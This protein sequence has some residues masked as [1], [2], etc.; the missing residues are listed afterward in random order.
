MSVVEQT[1]PVF[2]LQPPR[3]QVSA[4][5]YQLV[6]DSKSLDV[7]SEYLYLLL[8]TH[9]RDTCVTAF[10]K[11]TAV[12]A[13]TGYIRPDQKETLFIWQIAVDAAARQKGLGKKMIRHL[14][15]RRSCADVRFIEA[16][17]SPSNQASLNLFASLARDLKTGL[18]QT[19]CFEKELFRD[20]DHESEDLIRIGPFKKGND[21]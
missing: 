4:A 17:V 6:V 7:N 11:D 10:F 21:L 18:K 12:G 15:E 13:A 1:D 2:T 20:R 16:T 5:V 19:P 8:S 9:F 3:P 14:L